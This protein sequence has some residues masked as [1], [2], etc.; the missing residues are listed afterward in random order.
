MALETGNY[1]N[2]LN[3]TYP[4]ATDTISEGDGHLQLI[5]KVLK[6]SFAGVDRASEYIYVH[7]SAPTADVGKGRLWL[8][9]STT[10]NLLKICNDAGPPATFI[11]LPISA[12]V[13]YKLMGNDTV[14]WVL[15]TADGTANYPLTTTGSNVLAFAQLASAGIADDAVTT[16]KIINNAVDGTK[17][18]MGSDAAGDVLYHNGTDYVRLGKPSTPKGEILSFNTSAV[19]PSWVLGSGFYASASSGTSLS[20]ATLTRIA[21]ATEAYDINGDYA[22][23]TWTPAKGHYLIHAM[24]SLACPAG[25]NSYSKSL[26]LSIYKDDS[27][28]YEGDQTMMRYDSTATVSSSVT[29]TVYSDGSNT[30]D[31]YAYQ[32]SGSTITTDGGN[33]DRF[34]GTALPIGDST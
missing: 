2:D 4:T 22:T 8:D 17:I 20:S 7:T 33:T 6:Q 16:D 32:N 9:T 5:K 27:Q 18:A 25:I 26:I 23:P 19:A 10:P 3:E 15:P 11:K 28:V 12:T 30:W 31:I 13:N 34:L 24:V 29:A 21:F 14:G 1:L